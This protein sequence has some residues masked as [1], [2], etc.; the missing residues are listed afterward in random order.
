MLERGRLDKRAVTK[1]HGAEPLWWSPLS[2]IH[3]SAASSPTHTN[4]PMPI[5]GPRAAATLVDNNDLD[6]CHRRHKAVLSLDQLLH[7]QFFRKS[8]PNLEHLD[9]RAA[10]AEYERY[11]I[12]ISDTLIAGALFRLKELKY[13]S[14]GNWWSDRD[15]RSKTWTRAKIGFGQNVLDPPPSP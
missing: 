5:P 9:P 11:V 4:A 3:C 6:V 15:V 10:D 8:L 1:L 7:H 2:C 14:Q 13:Y 12:P